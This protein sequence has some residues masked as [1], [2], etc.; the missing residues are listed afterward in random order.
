MVTAGSKTI[1]MVT[2]LAPAIAAF[3]TWIGSSPGWRWAASWSC[4]ITWIF[5]SGA[6]PAATIFRTDRQVLGLAV[7]RA[8]PQ[9]VDG[10][11]RALP[12]QAR[13]AGPTRVVYS[14]RS[15]T[16]RTPR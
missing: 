5:P 3:A 13:R 6:E 12:R 10:S 9:E 8:K 14:S 16:V 4:R 11:L 7:A 1:G 2:V 15:A